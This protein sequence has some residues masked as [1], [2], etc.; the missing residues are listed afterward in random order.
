M[1]EEELWIND[2]VYSACM[3]KGSQL[4]KLQVR[5]SGVRDFHKKLGSV[6]QYDKREYFLSPN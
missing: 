6:G 5:V 1:V 3:F 4:N 2:L